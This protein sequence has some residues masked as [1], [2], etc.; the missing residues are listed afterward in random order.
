MKYAL[1]NVEYEFDIFSDKM[2]QRSEEFFLKE[3]RGLEFI[4]FF[5]NKNPNI[6]LLNQRDYSKE[7][8]NYLRSLGI[9]IPKMTKGHASFNWYGVKKDIE[10][11]RKLNSKIWSYD[12]LNKLFKDQFPYWVVADQKSGQEILDKEACENWILKPA[13]MMGGY[14]VHLLSST[15]KFPQIQHEHILEPK[16]N[17]VQDFALHYD[18]VSK[19]SF[20]YKSQMKLSGFYVGGTIFKKDESFEM[21]MQQFPYYETYLELKN[22]CHLILENIKQFD[23]AQP[24]TIDSFIYEEDGHYKVHPMCEIN[25]RMNMGTLLNSLREFLSEDGVGEIFF[26]YQNADVDYKDFPPFD[27]ENKNGVMLLNDKNPS[28]RLFFIA[29]PNVKVLRKL[30]AMVKHRLS[31]SF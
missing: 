22:K 24:L 20:F 17:R 7:Y 25:Y 15:E 30:K 2:S 3:R 4:F 6:G 23:L 10:L 28:N 13:H 26:V 19:E 16:Y 12:L 8:I 1:V 27:L 5:I 11:E 31:N 9:T 18:P 29:A 14:N 21:Y